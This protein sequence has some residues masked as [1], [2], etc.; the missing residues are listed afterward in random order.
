MVIANQV[1]Y[2]GDRDQGNLCP[3]HAITVPALCIH[4]A[5]LKM[6][7]IFANKTYNLL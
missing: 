5:L 4:S 3:G 2:E 1:S 7:G 6:S